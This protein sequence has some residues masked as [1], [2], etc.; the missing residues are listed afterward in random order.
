MGESGL[1]ILGK[2]AKGQQYKAWHREYKC[3]GIKHCEHYD[4]RVLSTCDAYDNVILS[5]IHKLARDTSQRFLNSTVTASLKAATE[6][7]YNSILQNWDIDA[8]PC[9]FRG[10]ERI[11]Q[12]QRL[13]F[14]TRRDVSLCCAYTC[15]C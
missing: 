4:E 14:I 13:R 2:D 7:L 8:G 3:T 5:D 11:C 9:R 15:R 1:P 12:G 10:Q 6:A